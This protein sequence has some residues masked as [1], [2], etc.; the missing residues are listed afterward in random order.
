[1]FQLL[2]FDSEANKIYD[3]PPP[4]PP[5]HIVPISE[6]GTNLSHTHNLAKSQS[7]QGLNFLLS[8]NRLLNTCSYTIDFKK[9]SACH[10]LVNI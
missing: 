1:M 4:P 6:G 2:M 5:K 3:M 7:Y 9:S 10:M 8:D